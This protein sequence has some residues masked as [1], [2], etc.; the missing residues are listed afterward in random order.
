MNKR[1]SNIRIIHTQIT[2]TIR[3]STAGIFYEEMWG[4]RFQYETWCFSDD[5]K[6]KTFQVI[7]GSCREIDQHYLKKSIKV[8]K[9]ISDNL[10]RRHN[11][12]LKPTAKDAAA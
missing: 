5:P 6:Q 10:I 9:Y 3:V 2:P 8:H 12:S 11:N 4:P 7:H 1:K